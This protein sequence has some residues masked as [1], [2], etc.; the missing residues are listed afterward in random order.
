MRRIAP[1]F[2]LLWACSSSDSL[3]RDVD[4]QELVVRVMG[5]E[6]PWVEPPATPPEEVQEEYDAIVVGGGLSGLTA[7]W[8]LRDRKVIVLERKDVA[9]GLAFSGT[10]GEGITYGRGAAYYAKPPDVVQKFYD[11][12]GMTPLAKTAIPEPIDSYFWKGKLYKGVWE[13]ETLKELP[14]EFTKFKEAL[15]KALDD[16]QIPDQPFED[17][18]D[19]SLDS[20]TAAEWIRPY[21]PEVKA[22][23]DSYC[24]S[25]LGSVTDDVNAAAFANFYISEIDVRYAWPGGTAGASKHLIEKLG[26]I[27][28]TSCAVTKVANSGDRVEV[29]YTSG[30][31]NYRARAKTAILATPLNVTAALMPEYPGER[32][33]LVKKLPFAD[34]VIH[35]VFTSRELF[36]ETYDTWFT[37]YSFTDLIV[38]RWC[39]TGGFEKPASGRGILAIYQPIAPFRK[40]PRMTPEVCADMAAEAVRELRA[41][42]PDL[43]KEKRLEVESYRWPGSIHIVPRHFFRD[44]APKLKE[45][46]GRVFF[47]GNN[48]GTPSF[49]EAIYRGWKAA[50]EARKKLM[51]RVRAPVADAA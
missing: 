49:E 42:I 41:M 20:L 30:G 25:A 9:G 31:K 7:A 36:T 39:E 17:A 45:P 46:V 33:E 38:S 4:G 40:I 16:G 35:T 21:G 37:E 1:L 32:R 5:F 12:M 6:T 51:S 11:E 29:V 27:V 26:A 44:W 23:L 15:E 10:T 13:E 43:A 34:Y 48:L 19:L 3:R 24:Q 47:A 28:R 14:S 8:Y 2:L 22:F 50:Q 18:A